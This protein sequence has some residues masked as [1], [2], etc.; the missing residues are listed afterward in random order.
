MPHTIHSIPGSGNLYAT[1][2]GSTSDVIQKQALLPNADT[3]VSPQKGFVETFCEAMT[4]MTLFLSSTFERAQKFF[5]DLMPN[6]K[7]ISQT[8]EP[9]PQ[10]AAYVKDLETFGLILGDLNSRIQT[11]KSNRDNNYGIKLP[12]TDCS[13]SPELKSLLNS[14]NVDPEVVFG[15]I[16]KFHQETEQ[17]EQNETFW[18]GI[19]AFLVAI[20]DKLE[21]DRQNATGLDGEL[22]DLAIEEQGNS[23]QKSAESIL[24]V[25][26]GCGVDTA[27]YEDHRSLNL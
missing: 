4:A 9:T 13:G 27:D 6:S 5:A 10:V 14:R 8:S 16:L 15:A 18:E 7:P 22:E 24:E 23:I 3:L 20:Q 17:P 11:A 26:K 1:N 25:V 2:P 19:L 12:K 21:N